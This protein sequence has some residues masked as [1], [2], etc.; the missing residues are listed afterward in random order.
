MVANGVTTSFS[1]IFIALL[2]EFGSS[3]AELSSIFSL[4][5][6]VFFCGG[7]LAGL[8][9][10]RIGP[11]RLIPLGSVLIGLGLFSCSRISSLY[12]LYLYYGLITAIG[13]CCISWVPSSVIITNWFWR[14]RGLAVG[15]VMCG[16]GLGLMVFLPLTQFL[17]SWLGW[18]SAFLVIAAIAVFIIAPLNAVFQRTRPEDKDLDG[19]P[20]DALLA[21]REEGYK[22]SLGK[23]GRLWAL[24]EAL[25]E[26]SFWM[27]CLA[28]F[29][30][31]F[32]TFS[33]TLHQV[34]LVVGRGFTPTAVA[35]TL[36]FVGIFAMV[37]RITGGMLSDRMGREWAYNL[38]MSFAA[39]GVISLFFL[40]ANC[41]WVLLIY[42]MFIGLGLGVG[43]AMFPPMIA[44]LFPG[45]SLGRII[46]I[47]SIFAGLGAGSGS[48]LV[49]YIHDLTGSYLWSLCCML[50]AIGAA[51]VS[52]WIAA[53]RQARR[54]S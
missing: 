3:R 11:R 5:I 23:S 31:P 1:V 4:Y 21:K 39:F 16:N 7:G 8:L 33:I 9:L 12:Q 22:K 28:S 15:I 30:N 35:A 27:I 44:D 20:I 14:R 2:A 52:V 6:L 46:G 19:E 25:R 13:T 54:F 38:F 51:V 18:R 41:S 45:P 49:G 47:T 50:V 40:N 36:G 29:F 26:K 37:G 48:W 34:T 24:S 17:T 32:F 10:D 42:V 53:P 43:G